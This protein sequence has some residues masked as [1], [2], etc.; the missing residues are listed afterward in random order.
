MKVTIK[1]NY[2]VQPGLERKWGVAGGDFHV[3]MEC[4][5]GKP[6]L[7]Y[8]QMRYPTYYMSYSYLNNNIMYHI[9]YAAQVK[10]IPDLNQKW[11]FS[12]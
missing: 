3:H 12:K 1:S 9:E 4:I 10:I 11:L 2:I 7:L 5:S 6:L 8:H